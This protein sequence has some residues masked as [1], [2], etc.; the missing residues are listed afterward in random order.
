MV[1]YLSSFEPL[2]EAIY[3][4]CVYDGE[5]VLQAPKVAWQPSD[6]PSPVAVRLKL[7]AGVFPRHAYQRGE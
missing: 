1:T 3:K 4:L 5:P 6:A 2:L 7:Q